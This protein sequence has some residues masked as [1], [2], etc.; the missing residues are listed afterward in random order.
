MDAEAY[1]RRLQSEMQDGSK[2]GTNTPANVPAD[3]FRSNKSDSGEG[4]ELGTKHAQEGNHREAPAALYDRRQS[5]ARE[6][7]RQSKLH[8]TGQPLRT[9]VSGRGHATERMAE[10]AEKELASHVH[11]RPEILY[12]GRNTLPSKTGR[13]PTAAA[14]RS[15]F[16][17]SVLHECTKA[18]PQCASERGHGSL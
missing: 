5:S 3:R 8:K 16:T 14:G 11:R 17:H 15:L 13:N 6:I 18:V 12:T 1:E 4:E 9:N 10:I 2:Q 7:A